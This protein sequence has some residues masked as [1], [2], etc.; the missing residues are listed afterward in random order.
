MTVQEVVAIIDRS[1]S[2]RGKESD[3]IGGI[4][5]TFEA[6]KNEMEEGDN[7]KVS[8]KLFD[9]EEFLLYNSVDITL[10]PNIT[11]KDY[12]P[13]GQTALLDAMGNTL[14]H[15]MEKKIKNNTCFDSCLIYIV[16]DGFENASK[17]FTNNKIS[18][19]IKEAEENYNIKLIYLGANQDAIV[20][21]A[22]YGISSDS[23]MNYDETSINSQAAYRSCA[24]VATRQRS[25]AHTSFTQAER[26]ASISHSPPPMRANTM[27]PPP[28][29]RQATSSRL[30]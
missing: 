5:S 14:A 2:M 21:A 1:G 4:N 18:K 9:H 8:V 27:Q 3:T 13:R 12:V 29:K 6:L 17:D 10:V 28:L 24:A 22:K 25:G 30:P 11:S 15:F 16:T 20:E 19:M 23:A 7:I 26:M